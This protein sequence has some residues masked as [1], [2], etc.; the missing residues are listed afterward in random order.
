LRRQDVYGFLRV[1]AAV[2]IVAGAGYGVGR[3][4]ARLQ[5]PMA[6]ADVP[7]YLSVLA[8]DSAGTLSQLILNEDSVPGEE[9]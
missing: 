6:S 7:G 2:A 9:I 3:W 8:S 4:T 5:A 1:A